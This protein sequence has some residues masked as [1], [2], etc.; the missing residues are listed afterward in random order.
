MIRAYVEEVS[1]IVWSDCIEKQSTVQQ[2]ISLSEGNNWFSTYLDITLDDLKAAL[3]EALPGTV[4]TIKS[5]LLNT[6]YNPNTNRWKGTL[7][8]FNVTQM[9]M[10]SV[11]NN[12]EITLTGTPINPAEHPVTISNGSNWIAFPFVGS[13]SVSNAFAGFAVNG[14]KVKSRNNN[15]QYQGGSWRGQLNT[16]VPGQGYMYISNTQGDRIFTFP[17]SAK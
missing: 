10:I 16:L 3:V 9:Y 4:I 14:D 13:M 8:S 5:R 11:S 7:T 6:A 2:S 17:T 15:T 1:E 12:C